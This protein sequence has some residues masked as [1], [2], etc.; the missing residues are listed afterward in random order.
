MAKLLGDLPR[1][2]I[3]QGLEVIFTE[4][5]G[6]DFGFYLKIEGVYRKLLYIL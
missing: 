2:F 4:N 3:T 6:L 1:K 5:K